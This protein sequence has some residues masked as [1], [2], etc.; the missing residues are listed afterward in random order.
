[1]VSRNFRYIVHALAGR[2]IL[3]HLCLLFPR[4]F[5]TRYIFYRLVDV[6]GHILEGKGF[7]PHLFEIVHVQ[8][9]DKGFYSPVL[10]IHGQDQFLKCDH[11]QDLKCTGPVPSNNVVQV[12]SLKH[13]LQL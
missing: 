8:L 3:D 11:I 7:P 1:M 4:Y 12:L 5:F 9:P 6:E 10:E 2:Q 13:P